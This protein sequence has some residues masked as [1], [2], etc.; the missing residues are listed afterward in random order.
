VFWFFS[1]W[2]ITVTVITV[3]PCDNQRIIIDPNELMPV[4]KGDSNGYTVPEGIAGT[5]CL[6][7]HKYGGLTLQVRVWAWC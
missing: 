3:S 6:R 1:D 2:F 7:G 4:V 5:P